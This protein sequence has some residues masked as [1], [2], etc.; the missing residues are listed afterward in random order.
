MSLVEVEDLT[1]RLS[2]SGADIVSSVSFGIESGETLALVGES[3]SGKTTIAVA[4]LGDTRRGAE[5][6]S[7]TV[8]I[9]D[10][11]LVPGTPRSLRAARGRLVAY[12]PQDPAAA[13]NPARR[14]GAQIAEA[15]VAHGLGESGRD[16][17]ERVRAVVGE[18]KLPSDRE[19]LGRFPHQLS[20]GQQQRVCI[21]IAAICEP[22]VLVLDEPTTGLD[23][24]TQAHILQTLGELVAGR[25]L[26]VLYVTHD[27]AVVANIAQRIM[28]LYAG[29]VAE[30]G[31]AG[32]VFRAPAHPYTRGLLGAVPDI[33]CRHVLEV[34]PG[35][36]PEPNQRPAGCAFAPRCA[37]A[38]PACREGVPELVAVPG[39]Q[40][41]ACLRA[42]ESAQSRSRTEQAPEPVEADIRTKVLEVSDLGAW[43]G[44]H[45]VLHHVS[46]ALLQGE[47]LAL[48]GESGS[49]KTTLARSIVGLVPGRTGEVRLDGEPLPVAT[50]AY[51]ERAKRTLQYIFQSPYNS[52]NP[53]RSVGAAIGTPLQHFFGLSRR[54]AEVKVREALERVALP[55]RVSG[56]YPDQLSGGER[57]RVAIARALVCEPEILLCDEIT[58]ALDVSVQAAIVELLADLRSGEG[59]SLLF[60]THNMGLVRSVADR[61]IVMSEGRLVETGATGALL[62]APTEDYTRTL[63]AHTPKLATA[64]ATGTAS[65]WAGTP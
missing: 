14:I 38:L 52:L 50:R 43:Y 62:D 63:V 10:T 47:C 57:Q 49:G 54:A 32:P 21:A 7:G 15:L 41:A 65:A 39:G 55:R 27:L 37:L 12:V 33:A 8:R 42:G 45:Q 51:P 3:G 2:S 61:V 34:I 24:S 5:L 59:L 40:V 25:G 6:A 46:F 31:Q 20:G 60:V 1:I 19:F 44:A 9:G 11:T 48:V 17:E 29:R 23:V 28:V 4:L 64:T 13:L 53:R 36:A 18:V 26:A 56:L 22:K 58:S 16:R 30:Y 35:L